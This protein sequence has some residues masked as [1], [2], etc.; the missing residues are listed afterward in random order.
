MYTLFLC[1]IFVSVWQIP[2]IRGTDNLSETNKTP[3]FPADYAPKNPSGKECANGAKR[4][5]GKH[6]EPALL[7]L[8]F[9]RPSL[10]KI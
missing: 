3:L 5:A 9:L 1:F 4:S 2:R 10:L 7:R 6:E 8:H